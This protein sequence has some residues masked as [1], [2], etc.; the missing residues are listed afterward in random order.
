MEGSVEAL[1][2]P[3]ILRS[4]NSRL[5]ETSVLPR[6][7]KYRYLV[8]YHLIR[9]DEDG[10]WRTLMPFPFVKVALTNRPR[11]IQL[12]LNK[13]RSLSENDMEKEAEISARKTLIKNSDNFTL[14]IELLAGALTLRGTS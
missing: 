6:F 13:I 12:Y 8:S 3:N 2:N 9:I 14:F 4:I 7:L 10:Y 11:T 5:I 1:K